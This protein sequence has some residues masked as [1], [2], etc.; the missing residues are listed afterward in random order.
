MKEVRVKRMTKLEQKLADGPHKNTTGFKVGDGGKIEII[1]DNEKD[2]KLKQ[3]EITPTTTGKPISWLLK[4]PGY[5]IG[6]TPNN[7]YKY[8]LLK[9]QKNVW[10]VTKE[11]DG[12]CHEFSREFEQQLTGG[13]DN[14]ETI[15]AKYKRQY[16]QGTLEYCKEICEEDNESLVRPPMFNDVEEETIP[17]V[18][19]LIWEKTETGFEAVDV[20]TDRKYILKLMAMENKKGDVDTYWVAL[21]KTL[22]SDYWC[23]FEH[24]ELRYN[25]ALKYKTLDSCKRVCQTE[26]DYL[27]YTNKEEI[28]MKKIN[29]YSA[30]IEELVSGTSKIAF[31]INIIPNNM[32]IN[33]CTVDSIDFESLDDGQ[34]VSVKINFIPEEK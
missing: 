3:I 6:S 14:T 27:R 17:T 16:I 2:Y 24:P 21:K 15:I 34:L 5:Y 20:G 22:T 4:E 18:Q 13:K 32:G 8:S 7:P 29:K 12:V 26:N 19:E 28:K 25:A 23:A 10:S 30:T 11:K 9:L 1:T 33:L 31:P